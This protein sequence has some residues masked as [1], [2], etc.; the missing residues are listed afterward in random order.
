MRFAANVSLEQIRGYP[1]MAA[2]HDRLETIRASLREMGRV[3]Q[4]RQQHCYHRWVTTSKPGSI[5]C[6]KCGKVE[7]CPMS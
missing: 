4:S 1:S 5:R 3:I 6:H 2:D 7:P